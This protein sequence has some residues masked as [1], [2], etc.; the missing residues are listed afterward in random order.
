MSK[1]KD[2]ILDELGEEAFDSIEDLIGAEQNYD[3]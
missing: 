3:I 1:I 2:Y